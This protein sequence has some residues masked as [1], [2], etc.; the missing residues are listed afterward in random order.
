MVENKEKAE[1]KN[2]KKI[3]LYIILI[4]IC[5]IILYYLIWPDIYSLIYNTPWE[6][7]SLGDIISAVIIILAFGGLVLVIKFKKLK[8]N[9]EELN[10]IFLKRI[11]F[12]MSILLI[13]LLGSLE[14]KFHFENTWYDDMNYTFGMLSNVPITVYNYGKNIPIYLI[15][16]IMMGIIILG[17]IE[18]I[19]CIRNKKEDEDKEVEELIQDTIKEGY[20]NKFIIKNNNTN[21]K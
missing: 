16:I 7:I 14:E 2:V 8:F 4:I 15:I 20:L 10:N 9:I 13:I 21:A 3:I 11:F 19:N 17:I 18:M 1:Q 6:L 5:G 12:P